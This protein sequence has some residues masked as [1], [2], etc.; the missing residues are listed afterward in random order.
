[1]RIDATY[2]V[3][4]PL[5]CAGACPNS[6]ELRLSSFKGALRYWWRALAWSRCGGDLSAIRNEE[7]ALF[8]SAS[9]GQSRMIIR[10]TPISSAKI[11]K[12]GE[13][14]RVPRPN[15]GVVGVGARYLGYG[16]MTAFASGKKAGELTR[17]C[18]Q[19]PLDFTVQIQLR[20]KGL[21]EQQQASLKKTLKKALIALGTFGGMGAKSRKGYGSL[22]LRSLQ[23]GTNEQWR[24]SQDVSDLKETIEDLRCGLEKPS[25]PEFTALTHGSRHI[26]LQSK[27]KYT[28]YP[29]ELLDLIG[30]ELQQ[31]QSAS[32]RGKALGDIGPERSASRVAFGLPRSCGRQSQTKI[33]PYEKGIDRRASPLFIHIH[34]CGASPVAV[35]S[36]LPSRFLPKGRSAISVGEHKVTQKSEEE[37]YRPVH[38]FLDRLGEERF[39][40]IE[41]GS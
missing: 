33:I 37:L 1:M 27:E 23:V 9:C 39:C 30:Q 12:E 4:T 40:A 28:I 22:V 14:L 8:G 10:L 11:S 15:G 29:I 5:F 17:A 20:G 35:L 7:D 19:A 24:S 25:L 26:I 38:N 36:F 34:E 18:F 16:L 13:M 3:V 32:K 21:D 31:F 41:V 6:A 2:R